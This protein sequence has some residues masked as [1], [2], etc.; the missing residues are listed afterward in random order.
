MGAIM[1]DEPMPTMS[2]ELRPGARSGTLVRAC[3]IVLATLASFG[4]VEVAAEPLLRPVDQAAEQPEFFSFRAQLQS[5]IARRD[6][7]ALV[8][9]LR[10]DIKNSFGGD[11]GIE[12]FRQVW[13]LGQPDSP[14]WEA[15]GTALA[16]GGSFSGDAGFAAPYVFSRWPEG[17]DSFGQV[18]IIAS[19]VRVR[20][21]PNPGAASVATLTFAIVELADTQAPEERWV[22]LKLPDG[23]VGYVDRRFVRS[24]IDY[25]AIFEKSEG[26]WQLAMFLA[27]D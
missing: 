25:R 17:A 26:R 20:A 21:E 14:L 2:S 15:L 4:S 24:P 16:L 13:Q 18:A 7:L 8:A 1:G 27:G 12:E 23:A 19:G 5:A 11:G 10:T 3:L 22:A 9:A 6:T